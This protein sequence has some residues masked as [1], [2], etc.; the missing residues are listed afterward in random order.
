MI[1]EKL[2]LH[3][4]I[5]L[6]PIL[7]VTLFLNNRKDKQSKFVLVVLLGVAAILCIVFS[8]KEQGLH[9]D[10]RYVLLMLAFLYGGPKAGWAICGVTLLTRTIVG[11][12]HLF[13][14]LGVIIVSS[15][16]FHLFANRYQQIVHKWERVRFSIMLIFWPALTQLT[17]LGIYLELSGDLNRQLGH[18]IYYI[19]VFIGAL[20]ISVGFATLLLEQLMERKRIQ[21]EMQRAVKLNAISELAASIAHEVRNPLTVVKGF[22]QLMQKDEK[23]KKKEYFN[24][25]L[26]EMNRAEQIISD[27]LNFAKPQFKTIQV[28]EV[29]Q[30]LHEIISF[31]TPYSLKENVE[32]NIDGT[33]NTLISS[34]K[35]QFKQVL[36]NLIKNAIEATPEK[37]QV[38]V[39]VEEDQTVVRITIAD[40]GKGMS[41]EQLAKIGTLFYSTKEKG[42]GLGTM[43]SF[44]IIEEMGGTLRYESCV[45][46]GT[47][48]TIVMPMNQS[49]KSS[50]E[51][52]ALSIKND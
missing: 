50:L 8:F 18:F 23:G 5:V 22:L 39:K 12:E 28:I 47:K 11:G 51:V 7:V 3:L 1:A 48:V 40:N 21:E 9:W 38:T 27:Y 30:I 10:L 6:M 44:R 17:L 29:N 37:G 25:A 43:V 31:L 36:I 20:V 2:L 35:N 33:K 52:A 13:I 15:L 34:D 19:L 42:T 49:T 26:H 41:Q 32:L 24:I 14:G 16:M 46:V 4:L 45:N